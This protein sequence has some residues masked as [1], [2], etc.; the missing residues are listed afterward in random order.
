MSL[1][2]SI[3]QIELTDIELRCE[4][5]H[6]TLYFAYF[7][8]N[9]VCWKQFKR[10]S[11]GT[12]EYIK[13][14]LTLC[15]DS[16]I[17]PFFVTHYGYTEEPLGI[18]IS[19]EELALSEY[20]QY[21]NTKE[22]F[23]VIQSLLATL[24][25]LHQQG[26]YHGRLSPDNI[27]LTFNRGTL[28]S[29]RLSHPIIPTSSTNSIP[30]TDLT[31][32]DALL[33]KY[34]KALGNCYT[35]LDSYSS[36]MT[37]I[38]TVLSKA[39][40]PVKK[41]EKSVN[42]GQ[43]EDQK[44]END[45][46]SVKESQAESLKPQSEPQSPSKQAESEESVD[47][48]LL[49]ES[50]S[51]EDDSEFL[52]T[53]HDPLIDFDLLNSDDEIPIQS[54]DPDSCLNDQNQSINDGPP[55]NFKQ[56]LSNDDSLS[57]ALRNDGSVWSW[58]SNK[59]RL[60]VVC[61]GDFRYDPVQIPGLSGIRSICLGKYTAFAIDNQGRV[62]AWGQGWSTEEGQK[63]DVFWSEPT[64]LKTLSKI[65]KIS[66]GHDHFLALTHSGSV[67]GWGNGLV[68]K[69][70]GNTTESPPLT[71]TPIFFKERIV[72]ICAS[73][74]DSFAVGQSGT[75]YAWGSNA[76]FSSRHGDGMTLPKTVPVTIKTINDVISIVASK[77]AVIALKSDGSVY[78]WGDLYCHLAR[79]HVAYTTPQEVPE[80]SNISKIAISQTHSAA[81]RN[82][83]VLYTWGWNTKSCVS[84]ELPEDRFIPPS[85]VFL[86]DPVL[87]VAVGPH[88][89]S[90]IMETGGIQAWGRNDAGQLGGGFMK[91][92]HSLVIVKVPDTVNNDDVMEEDGDHS[93]IDLPSLE[94]V[95]ETP[96]LT[97]PSLPS[98]LAKISTGQDFTV[99]LKSDGTVW[100]WGKNTCHQLGHGEKDA[101]CLIPTRVPELNDVVAI[102]A[103]HNTVLA[104]RKDETF[105]A[106]GRYNGRDRE[107]PVQTKPIP[108]VNY[109]VVGDDFRLALT[110]DGDVLSWGKGKSGVLG[111][112]STDNHKSAV[113]VP[114]LPKVAQIAAGK[115]HALALSESGR[116]YSWGNNDHCQLGN[117][118]KDAG[119][120]A[121]TTPS[122]IDCLRNIIMIAAGDTSSF[123]V[124]YKGNVYFWGENKAFALDS[125]WYTTPVY[126]A[127]LQNLCHISASSDHALFLTTDNKLHA[128]GSNSWGQ[129]GDGSNKD[130][131]KPINLSINNVA[132][133]IT[134]PSFSIL[135]QLNNSVHVFG[136]NE[137]GQLGDCFGSCHFEPF[138]IGFKFDGQNV[139]RPNPHSYYLCAPNPKMQFGEAHLYARPMDVSNNEFVI[140]LREDKSLW[141]WGNFKY[142][143]MGTGVAGRSLTPRELSGFEGNIQP[144]A[145]CAT[146]YSIFVLTAK[147]KV[148]GAG[149]VFFDSNIHPTQCLSFLTDVKWISGGSGHV[150]A[151]KKDGTVWAWGKNSKGQVGDG[152]NQDKHEPVQVPFLDNIVHV[153]ASGDLSFAVTSGG[154]VWAWGDN[155]EGTLGTGSLRI[156][157]FNCPSRIGLSDIQSIHASP[158]HVIAV[159]RSNTLLTWG[160]ERS[161]LGTQAKGIECLVPSP[162]SKIDNVS[163]VSAGED[164]SFIITTDRNIF[165]YGWNSD[166]QTALGVGRKINV[167]LP[168][169]IT[170][171]IS[172]VRFALAGHRFSLF[173][174]QDDSV[175]SI[176]FNNGGV[177]G[178]G[179]KESEKKLSMLKFKS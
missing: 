143:Q 10:P 14:I 101:K 162:I 9:P 171:T 65:S 130:C 154:F 4:N 106:W 17:A 144:T 84:F 11:S 33:A 86:S 93:S 161:A 57:I 40:T 108:N 163:M 138:R 68:N 120:K 118:L 36:T 168:L 115:A 125:Q 15:T 6:F 39:E 56:I 58:G 159:T 128:V 76:D 158:R 88:Y 89:T 105:I 166:A 27:F 78:Q 119:E 116:V 176:G 52:T 2:R 141:G 37:K 122:K 29:I 75:L 140:H 38:D 132:H 153:A 146:D 32:I 23:V 42:K 100:S 97:F 66:A 152:T 172:N 112:G 64:L 121:Y 179:S 177:L 82:D 160:S 117:G 79:E 95:I 87:D 129:L 59:S 110:N 147:G 12:L 45:T 55:E 167:S 22:L 83:G 26:V 111:L 8:G 164:H 173:V 127:N 135:I 150:L 157:S 114:A 142:G 92:T 62:Y 149:D 44:E 20:H 102:Y 133:V 13:T 41:E 178:L 174:L 28:H 49:L 80:L 165:G 107:I 1:P 74:S 18:V 34:F 35:A 123:A 70:I 5:E 98:H 85:A 139:L 3:K 31:Q 24:S 175:L 61:D 124:D 113:R 69:Y 131:K 134:G 99:A 155:Y 71:P 137:Y 43:K 145:V 72:D 46:S 25:F 21:F 48:S 90:V 169:N 67:F 54:T 126:F 151:L 148:Y 30:A 81:L 47:L 51:D 7:Q 19:Q 136:Y 73:V 170:N 60:L 104:K 94:V 77:Y 16:P 50:S 156:K 63:G 91:E 96:D 103:G 53:N 109:I